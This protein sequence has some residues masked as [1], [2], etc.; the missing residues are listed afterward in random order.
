MTIE[1]KAWPKIARLNRDIYITEK[2]DGTNAAVI[3][4][5][6][7]EVAAQSRSRV[8]TPEDDNFGFAAWVQKNATALA[9]VLGEGYHFGEWWGGGIQRKYG[10][11]KGA[12]RFSLFNVKRWQETFDAYEENPQVHDLID[13]GCDLVP[14]LYQGPYSE[15]MIQKALDFLRE[16]GSQASPG[17]MDP[18]GVVVYHVAANQMFKVTLKGDD[19]PKSVA[20]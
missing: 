8:I 15:E 10:L 14:V 5:E 17:F 9:E 19:A 1:F 3:V 2:I 13:E 11:E 7:G 12:K 20:S 4:T 16:R 18:E 6:N